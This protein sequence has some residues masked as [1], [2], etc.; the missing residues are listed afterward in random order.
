[1]IDRRVL[2]ATYVPESGHASTVGG[3]ILRS[4]DRIFYEFEAEQER[5]GC[6]DYA[7]ANVNPAG[8]YIWRKIEDDRVRM[9]LDKC[10]GKDAFS[11]LRHYVERIKNLESQI[12]L[13]LDANQDAFAMPNSVN[14]EDELECPLDEKNAVGFD[15]SRDFGQS[16]VSAGKSKRRR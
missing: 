6:S 15:V 11:K 10:W 12:W 5:L 1:M 13:W 14:F 3:E 2:Y 8:R 9:A 16:L 7:E 4:M